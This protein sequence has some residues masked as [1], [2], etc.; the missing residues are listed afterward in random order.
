MVRAE[1]IQQD[2]P[3]FYWRAGCGM[4]AYAVLANV[5]FDRIFTEV[6]AIVEAYTKGRPAA[7]ELFGPEVGMGGPIW[8][9]ISYGHV[10]TLGCKLI[11][12]EDS[13][14]AHEPIYGSLR[15]GIRA[16]KREVDFAG[17]GMFPFYLGL[18]NKLRKAFP[19][20]E[21]S[22]GGFKSEG[23]LTTAW[24]LRGHDFFVD[25]LEY[26]DDAK[27]YLRLVTNSIIGYNK[28]LRRV[29]GLPEF[30]T[31]G[32]GMADDI[33]AMIAPTQWLEYVVPFH[34]QY[35]RGQ[36]H[37]QRS[38]HIEDLT[39]AHLKYL[40]TINLSSYD[41]SVSE[42]LTPALIRDHCHVPF[43]W[44]LNTTHY[45]SRSCGDIERWVLDAV[46]NGAVGVKTTVERV[47]CTPETAKKVRAFISACKKVKSLL[48][49]DPRGST[50]RA[51]LKKLETPGHDD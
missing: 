30:S 37:G 9:M 45:P 35:Y 1:A 39:V 50:P 44:M 13:E 17:Q 20:K 8:P 46:A 10:N 24:L 33:S 22:F 32:V 12:P 25:L 26:P 36:T 38:A 19:H 23:P 5:R 41:P 4:P 51:K 29:N 7:Q 2:M 21:I 43:S 48:D 28:L 15:E 16:L 49:S 47:M 18:W 6:D 11:F 27:E 14:V 42:K 3:T 40:D 34:E 31:D